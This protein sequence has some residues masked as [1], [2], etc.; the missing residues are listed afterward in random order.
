VARAAERSLAG[1]IVAASAEGLAG[2]RDL[3]PLIA[4]AQRLCPAE[5]RERM[6]E[7]LDHDRFIVELVG[8]HRLTSLSNTVG[9]AAV[10]RTVQLD[11]STLVSLVG[12]TRLRGRLTAIDR[13]WVEREVDGD[14][15]A[16]WEQALRYIADP[17]A[18]HHESRRFRDGDEK[19]EQVGS[20]V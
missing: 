18:G 11:W 7:W 10:R 8:A 17:D 3:G 14:T 9:E 16:V 13:S 20:T 19:P 4:F 12:I 2:E 6:D 1:M 5:L 15:Y